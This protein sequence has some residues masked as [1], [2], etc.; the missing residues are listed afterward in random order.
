MKRSFYRS[1]VALP[2][3][4]C[5]APVLAQENPDVES[6]A[7]DESTP[8]VVNYVPLH[9]AAGMMNE[10]MHDGG[11]FMLGLRYSHA[12]YRGANQSGA[13]D[14]TDAEIHAAGYGVRA[15]RMQ[16]DMVML[17][18]MYAPNDQLTLMVMPHWMRHEM[19]MI[20]IDPTNTGMN[21]GGMAMGHGHGGL[22][23]GQSMSHS[24][25]GFGDTLVSGSLRLARSPG[26]NAH[27]T[28]GLW[29]PT[30]K[31][32][33]TNP[34]GSFVHY[35]MQS[36]SGTWDVEPSVTIS[37]ATGSFGWGA[38]ASYRW[39][40]E[41]R[42]ESGFAFGDKAMATIW[43]SYLL[44]PRASA[45]SRLSWEHEGQILGHYNGPH[46]HAA[47]PDRQENY[48]GDKVL[49]GLGINLALP[50]GGAKPP[51][52]GFEAAVPLYQN[53]NGIQLSEDWRLSLSI[54]KAF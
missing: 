33:R 49:A 26:F 27:V 9:P 6:S 19:T 13:S 12:G 17:D 50:L 39:R 15:T 47:P 45:T 51:Q 5:A 44:S 10:H 2:F 8:I 31:V 14:I 54:S 43:G 28:M 24:T 3:L 40:S 21:M 16:M 23:I 7:I 11:E 18:I 46:G 38:Q 36:G 30:G 35:G 42:N 41:E 4:L 34:D 22:P 32:D 53:L 37:G 1:A 52:L 20:G 25:Q 29:L 48:G